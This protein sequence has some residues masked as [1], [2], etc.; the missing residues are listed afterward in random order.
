[1][2][3]NVHHSS[4]PVLTATSLFYLKAKNSTPQQN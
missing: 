3:K 4:S 2:L 1:L